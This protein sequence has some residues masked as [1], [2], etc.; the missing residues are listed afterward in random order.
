[1]NSDPLLTFRTPLPEEGVQLFDLIRGC[2]PLDVN[3]VY[4]YYLLVRHFAGTC[5]VAIHQ[6]QRVGCITAYLRPDKPDTLFIWQVAVV[7]A[8]RGKGLARGMLRSLLERDVC[9]SVT[10][11]ET[12]VSPSNLA[13][14][15]M[16]E[17]FAD[18]Q[19]CPVECLPF[20]GE[21]QF[22]AIAH[23]EAEDLLRIG[24]MQP[25]PPRPP[26]TKGKQHGNI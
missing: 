25:H 11:L 1:M 16:F 13:S 18:E 7:A 15:R 26:H 12:T 2:P 6:Q 21:D 19:S 23:H 3:S 20:L 24:P 9:R 14:R 4:C 10:Y 22:G 5:V 8:W 17:R